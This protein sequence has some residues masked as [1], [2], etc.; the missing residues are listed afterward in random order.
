MVI[1]GW[2]GKEASG[3]VSARIH[4]VSVFDILSSVTGLGRIEKY[5]DG[6]EGK[7]RELKAPPA[8]GRNRSQTNRRPL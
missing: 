3:T 4:E 2:C 7:R 6:F 1:G 8:Q 5:A